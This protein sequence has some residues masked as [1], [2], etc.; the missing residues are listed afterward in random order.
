MIAYTCYFV[1]TAVHTSAIDKITSVCYNSFAYNLNF[2]LVTHKKSKVLGTL[3][4]CVQSM[5]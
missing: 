5:A 1:N 2:M 3:I 4:V